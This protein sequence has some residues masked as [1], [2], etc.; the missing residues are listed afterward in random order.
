[1]KRHLLGQWR[2]RLWNMANG[3]SFLFNYLF[4]SL[5]NYAHDA[6]LLLKV[7]CIYQSFCTYW[8]RLCATGTPYS[9]VSTISLERVCQTFLICRF[10]TTTGVKRIFRS[11]MVAWVFVRSLRWHHLPFWHQLRAPMIYNSASSF[12]HTS[13]KINRKHLFWN[14]GLTQ[15]SLLNQSEMPAIFKR[16]GEARNRRDEIESSV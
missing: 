2:H 8:G 12:V 14:N 13:S 15:P 5:I 3:F 16:L 4:S 10:L 1:M 7:R 6:L 9:I 11:R